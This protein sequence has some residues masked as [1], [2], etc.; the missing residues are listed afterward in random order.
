VS[1]KR[2]PNFDG[3][4]IERDTLV[5]VLGVENGIERGNKGTVKITPKTPMPGVA[6]LHRN[7]LR[8]IARNTTSSR[9][10]GGKV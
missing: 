9:N 5:Y 6:Q 1:H 3:Y 4:R 8:T 10:S 7:G 2:S